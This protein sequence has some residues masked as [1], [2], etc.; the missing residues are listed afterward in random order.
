MGFLKNNIIRFKILTR[1]IPLSIIFNFRYL[2]F[3]QAVKLPILLYKPKFICLKGRVVI[4]NPNIKYGMIRLGFRNVSVF[5]NSGITWQNSGGIITFKGKCSIGNN[6]FISIGKTGNITLGDDFLGNTSL[7]LISYRSI[8]FGKRTR[9]G[10]ENLV[11]DTNFHPLKKLETGE[12]KKASGPIEI[13]DYNW[14]ANKCIIMH[15]VKTPERCLFGLNSVITRGGSFESYCLHG[16]NPLRVLA[17]G[18]YRDLED[19]VETYE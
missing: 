11:M 12:K 15:S 14:F 13:G 10:W 7:K 18:I 8:T 2:P 4:D 19:D 1:A 6:S 5:P 3:K 9:M 16:G 17:R